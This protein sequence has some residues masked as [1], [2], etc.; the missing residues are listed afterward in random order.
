MYTRPGT[1]AL[2]AAFIALRAVLPATAQTKTESRVRVFADIPPIA[3]FVQRVGGPDVDVSVL[4]EPGQDPHTFE[5]TPK[6]AV[7]L[8]QARILFALGFPF[9]ARISRKAKSTFKN[10]E[11]V[12]LQRGIRLRQESEELGTDEPHRSE[13]GTGHRHVHAAGELDRH[14]WL[15]P[16]LAKIQARTIAGA[17]SRVD[18]ENRARYEANLQRFQSDLDAVHKRLLKALAPVRGKSFFVFHPAYGYLGTSLGLK[19]IAVQ[20]GGKEP[21]ARQL[22]RLIETAKK[23]GV[24]VIFVQPQFAKTSADAVAKAIG[25]AAVSLD[26]LAENYLENL[27]KMVSELESALSVQ[28]RLVID[29]LY[30]EIFEMPYII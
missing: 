26:P 6:M 10:L 20:E 7:K 12:D 9:E 17:L 29:C 2:I 14:T 3:Y 24:R 21:T 18:P 25:G 11:V 16:Q 8:A 27:R 4:V 15:D 5:L 1:I 23:N 28:K 13:K 22:A 19:Q 30:D